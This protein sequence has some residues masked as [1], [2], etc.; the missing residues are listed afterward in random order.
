M[1][2]ELPDLKKEQTSMSDRSAAESETAVDSEVQNLCNKKTGGH[3]N[4]SLPLRPSEDGSKSSSNPIES[5]A[6]LKV[7]CQ[8]NEAK[9]S[10]EIPF[11][12]INS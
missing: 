9:S 8:N 10:T 1:A 3:Q 5:S 7:E 6:P 11:Q 12:V 4:D 2:K